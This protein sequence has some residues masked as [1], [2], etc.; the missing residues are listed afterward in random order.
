MRSC[1]R[2]LKDLP[3]LAEGD[4]GRFDL[5]EAGAVWTSQRQVMITETESFLRRAE[6]LGFDRAAFRPF[7]P[8][9]PGFVSRAM[10]AVT[11]LARHGAMA[12]AGQAEWREP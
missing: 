8:T 7:A 5:A 1:F 3:P 9:R 11:V 2:A 6:A 4:R 12:A 10:A